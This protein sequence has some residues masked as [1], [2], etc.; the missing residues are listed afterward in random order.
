M[1]ARKAFLPLVV[2][3]IYQLPLLAEQTLSPAEISRLFQQANKYFNLTH[4][5]ASTD[6][7]ALD[8]FDQVIVASEQSHNAETILFQ[9]Y[10]NKGVLLDVQG[11][12]AEAL[13][14]YQGALRCKGRNQ[15]WSDSL[16]FKVYIYA[17]PDY[18]QLEILD[19]AY[20]ML[21][22][23]EL[24][25]DK[26]P[27]L[28]DRERLYNS[29]GALYYESGNYIQS[30]DYFAR[31]LEIVHKQKPDDEISSANFK[32]N[33]ASCLY[34]LGEYRQSLTIYTDLLQSGHS[35]DQIYFNVGRS[36]VA[37]GNI[38]QA[39]ANYQKVRTTIIPGVLNEMAYAQ[40]LQKKMD[41]ALYYLDAWK[42]T[43]DSSQ[44]TRIDAGL[45]DLYRTQVLV[46]KGESAQA[47]SFLQQAIITFSGSFRNPDIQANPTSFVGSFAS[48]RLFDALAYKAQLLGML[49]HQN[50]KEQYLQES[51]RA[52]EGAINLFRYIEKTYTTD[53]AK[54]FLKK[55][56]RTLYEQA[57]LAY[58]ELNR[59][60]PGGP[61]LEEA[62]ITEEKSKS[63]IVTGRLSELALGKMP[64]IDPL[65][66][67]KQREVKYN[68]ARL[69]LK[70]D[71]G[72]Q[73]QE[74]LAVA[75]KKADYEIELSLLQKSLEANSAYY[76][77]KFG[78]SCPTVADLQ[79]GLSA[80]QAIVSLFV[81]EAGLHLFTIT[82]S[83]FH[84]QLID[85][86][87]GL[88]GLVKSWIEILNNTVRGQ[89]FRGQ[90]LGSQLYKHLVQPLQAALP[91]KDEWIIIPDGMYYLLPFES[92][93]MDEDNRPLI[94]TTTISYQLS[95]KFL[96]EPFAHLGKKASS[97][98]VLSFAPF[99]AKAEWVNAP[100]LRYLDQL[101]NSGL[102][103]SNLAGEQFLNEQATKAHF[104]G[105]INHYP[106][107]HLATHA[108]ADPMNEKGSLICFYPQ[109]QEAQEDC[110]FLPELYGLILDSTNLVIL[111]ACE[112][113]RGEIVDNEGMMSLSRGFMY[114][115][116]ASTVNSLWKA[117]D[118]S[119]A[120]ILREFHVYLEKG[121]TK[122]LALRQAKLDYLH[123][124][125]VYIT[126]NYWAHLILIGNTEAIVEKREQSWIT[127]CILGLGFIAVLLIW[128]ARS[129][130]LHRSNP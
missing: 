11:Q 39:M 108:F 76:K 69:E 55:N 86:S 118:E 24:L 51:I 125:A 82:S 17:G 1:P 46:A 21:N 93:P 26:F 27:G 85:S 106:V 115:G 6:S 47:V 78:D 123:S 124:G 49:Y 13:S 98:S 89:R 28:L 77:M 9:S 50:G 81:S 126:P 5:T 105:A 52:Y 7:K 42:S 94:E 102:E 40:Y 38:G 117:D 22:R 122:A 109:R 56:N 130:Y 129:A 45:N 32:N 79:S 19:S 43:V 64:G 29:L 113:G 15:S 53:D 111:S 112:S 35:S 3:L 31:A 87:A 95:A 116:C 74:L 100:G 10:I 16:L 20:D 70:S 84:Y 97:Y 14:A 48:Y 8:L 2:L 91:G 58:L 120:A 61:Y 99:A 54:L 92:L 128:R 127:I 59:L 103:I 25:A 121:Y 4:P 37:I 101:P 36:F 104:L 88:S 75:S 57:V 67:K 44:K 30:K 114:A 83:S 90:A 60:H 34:K 72:R 33:I 119:T 110:L 73:S 12:F 107:I 96:A 66:L 68:I 23:A 62:F 80:N 65:I 63:S 18:Y 71:G 41:S